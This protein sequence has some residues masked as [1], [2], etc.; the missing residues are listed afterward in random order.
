MVV[1]VRVIKLQGRSINSVNNVVWPTSEI[2]QF[3]YSLILSFIGTIFG[4]NLLGETL[5]LML[6]YLGS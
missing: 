1:T 3:I 6:A 2:H 5:K 4:S